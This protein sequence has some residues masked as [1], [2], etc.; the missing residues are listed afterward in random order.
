MLE[1]AAKRV[2]APGGT[3]LFLSATPPDQ[4]QQAVRRNYVQ[5]AKI[6]SRYH[7]HPLPVPKI[8]LTPTLSKI[9]AA[10]RLPGSLYAALTRA[11]LRSAQL[12][13]F[14]PRIDLVDR[15]VGLLQQ[16]FPGIRV[17][18]T[19]SVDEERANKVQ[20]FRQKE[21]RILVTTTILERGVTIP[22][23]D[24]FIL[25]G[26]APIFDT[27]ALIQMAGRAGRSKDDPCGAVFFTGK[28]R[29]RAQVRAIK[30]IKEMNAIAYKKGYIDYKE[31]IN[32]E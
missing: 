1:Y 20:L 22:K 26:D 10:N 2:V 24:V 19:S 3:Y 17:A 5:C 14:V 11:V 23:S 31:N 32:K 30:Q 12:F 27:A 15:T 8:L 29:T 4:L 18:G 7:R 9:I 28:E 21:I 6:P 16:A 13:V 25:D